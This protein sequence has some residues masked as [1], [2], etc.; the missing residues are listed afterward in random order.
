MR[1][2][3]F[4]PTRRLDTSTSSWPVYQFQHSRKSLLPGEDCLIIIS[5][6][7]LFVNLYFPIFSR[8]NILSQKLYFLGAFSGQNP[9][10]RSKSVLIAEKAFLR[11][12]R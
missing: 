1:L 2:T 5:R 10:Q 9:P 8:K 4:E 3:G 7:D 11:W 12:G 6:T